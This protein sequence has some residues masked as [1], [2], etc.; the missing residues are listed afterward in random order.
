MANAIKFNEGTAFTLKD[1][2]GDFTLTL[3]ALA[4]AAARQSAKV[5]LTDPRARTWAVRV[6]VQF[7]SA[8]TA[9][10]TVEIYWAASSSGTAANENDG[11]TTGSD[12]AY[13]IGADGYKQMIFVG[14]LVVDNVASNTD[15]GATFLF[16]PPTRYGNLVLV[17]NT[18]QALET[19]TDH[20][21]KLIPEDD[22]VQ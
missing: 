22:E 15:Q 14:A 17:N 7:G 20:Y 3:S 13:S 18:S 8:P 16:V 21:V 6:N 5:D 19:S 4:S 1:S 11:Q 12:A 2:G 9:G 10:G